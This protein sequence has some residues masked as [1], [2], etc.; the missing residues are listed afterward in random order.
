[1]A[2][3]LQQPLVTDVVEEA[4]DTGFEY[5]VHALISQLRIQR[6]QRHMTVASRLKPARKAPKVRLAK[7]H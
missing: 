2:D 4:Q 1:M 7:S 3:E 5:A 6:V